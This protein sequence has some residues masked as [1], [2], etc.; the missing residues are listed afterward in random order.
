MSLTKHILIIGG[1]GM[2]KGT[3]E[4]FLNRGDTVSVVARNTSKI[5]ELS[6]RLVL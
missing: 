3:V 6:E 1:T 5:T 4:Y 2:L